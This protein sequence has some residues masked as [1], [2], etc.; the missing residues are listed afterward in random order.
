MRCQPKFCF[1][2]GNCK[3]SINI[4]G[5]RNFNRHFHK[6]KV[7]VHRHLY[8][9]LLRMREKPYVQNKYTAVYTI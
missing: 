1:I 9:A 6:L 7:S 2:V 8:N 4:I 5:L 3:V